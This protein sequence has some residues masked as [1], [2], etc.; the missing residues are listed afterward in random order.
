MLKHPDICVDAE[1][2]ID[3]RDWQ[4]HGGPDGTHAATQRRLREHPNCMACVREIKAKLLTQPVTVVKCKWGK[5]R[6]VGCLEIAVED[7]RNCQSVHDVDIIV[8]HIE[9]NGSDAATR[10]KLLAVSR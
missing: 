6:S 4:R 7:L 1:A 10:R 3:H 9:L 8:K 5:H 2:W